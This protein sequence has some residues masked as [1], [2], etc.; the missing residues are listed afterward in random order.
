MKKKVVRKRK[1]KVEPLP[2]PVAPTRRERLMIKLI[3]LKARLRGVFAALK[4]RIS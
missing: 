4:A 3:V 1:A 2:E